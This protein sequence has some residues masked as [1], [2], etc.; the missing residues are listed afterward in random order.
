MTSTPSPT[1]AQTSAALFTEEEGGARQ[2]SEPAATAAAAAEA[3]DEIDVNKLGTGDFSGLDI[4]VDLMTTSALPDDPF[5]PLPNTSDSTQL[6]S[7]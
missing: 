5:A 6:T 4:D 3:E 7:S 2:D 1:P